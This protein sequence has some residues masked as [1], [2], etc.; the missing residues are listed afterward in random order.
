[1]LREPVREAQRI[2]GSGARTFDAVTPTET[3]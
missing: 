3:S 2:R 1:M